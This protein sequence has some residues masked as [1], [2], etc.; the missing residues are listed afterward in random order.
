MSGQFNL[1][2]MTQWLVELQDLIQYSNSVDQKIVQMG[3]K[4]RGKKTNQED[5]SAIQARVNNG[6]AWFAPVRL[7]K[8]QIK[9]G[10]LME[11]KS[12]VVVVQSLSHVRLFRPHREQP[13]TVAHHPLSVGFSRL[14][15]WSGL[16]FPS[17]W[18]LPH[19]GIK[20]GSPTVQEVSLPTKPP[21][22]PKV[23]SHWN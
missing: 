10:E 4:V 13:Q 6:S 7:R 1:T 8:R 22:K 21:G 2:F 11:V 18:Y 9:T 15:Y 19:S 12:A 16:P 17:S 20:P 3:G 5:F 14:E 23:C